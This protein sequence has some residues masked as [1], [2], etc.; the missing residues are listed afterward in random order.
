VIE[1]SLFIRRESFK[2]YLTKFPIT[3]LI[4]AINVIYFILLHL[5]PAVNDAET[6]FK[7][8]AYYL[9]AVQNGEYHRLIAPVFMQIDISHFIFN[10]FSIF[11]FVSV[12]EHLIGSGRF[13]IIYLVSGIAGYVTTFLFS[14]SY[15]GLGASGAI[16]GV[17]G[18]FLYLSMK[19][20]VLLDEASRKTII[21]ILI[22]NLIFTFIDPGISITG[23]IGGFVV[24]YA[25]SA[26]LR[27]EQT[28]R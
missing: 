7:W 22:L 21:P 14:A 10:V 19:K 12:L 2:Q 17:L 26:L 15:L 18:A 3:T 4:I 25:L 5:F 11:M 20:S 23:H 1:L 9:P 8:G 24:G 6:I 28:R 16:F 13:I 27:I